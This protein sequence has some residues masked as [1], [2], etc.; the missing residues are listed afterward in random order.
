MPDLHVPVSCVPGS[1]T[2]D[3]DKFALRDVIAGMIR[4]RQAQALREGNMVWW[5]T[6]QCL[7]SPILAGTGFTEEGTDEPLD[8]WLTKLRFASVADGATTGH[9]PLRYAVIAGRTDLVQ[10]MLRDPSVDVNGAIHARH[11][12]LM[13]NM[14]PGMSILH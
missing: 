11:A 7:T 4:R 1:F 5:R 8:A 13:F 6:L 10:A 2:V 3:S 12:D 9:T 14:Q